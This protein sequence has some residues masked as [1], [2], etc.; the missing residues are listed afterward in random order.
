MAFTLVTSCILSAKANNIKTVKICVDKP[1]VYI[2]NANLSS[3]ENFNLSAGINQLVFEGV[4]PTLDQKF[5]QAQGKGN[6][7]IINVKYNVTYR[8]QL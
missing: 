1:T 6:L 4:A 2:A 8:N 7:V 5:L 3:T